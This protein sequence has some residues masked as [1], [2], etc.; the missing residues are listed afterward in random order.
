MTSLAAIEDLPPWLPHPNLAYPMHLVRPPIPLRDSSLPIILQLAIDPEDLRGI[1]NNLFSFL[2]I[3]F[4]LSGLALDKGSQKK[5]TRDPE[6]Q[7]S[8]MCPS[9]GYRVQISQSGSG[10][11][12][13]SSSEGLSNCAHQ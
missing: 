6:D 4:L 3:V 1:K 7:A 8:K 2:P 12:A 9:G 10:A 11:P 5:K 13:L